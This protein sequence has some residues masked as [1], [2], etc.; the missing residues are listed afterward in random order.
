MV[1]FVVWATFESIWSAFAAAPAPFGGPRNAMSSPTDDGNINVGQGDEFTFVGIPAGP[2]AYAGPLEMRSFTMSNGGT[3]LWMVGVG[4]SG[5]II[6]PTN[7]IAYNTFNAGSA[8]TI[9]SNTIITSFPY[10]D[11]FVPIVPGAADAM[12]DSASTSEDAGTTISVLANDDGTGNAVTAITQGANGGTVTNNGTSVTYNP[13]GQFEYLAVGETAT[14]TFTYTITDG[15]GA[16]DTATVTVTITGAN[17]APQIGAATTINGTESANNNGRNIGGPAFVVTDVDVSDVVTGSVTN[18][19]QSGDKAGVLSDALLLSIAKFVSNDG[20]PLIDATETT[21]PSGVFRFNHG[22]DNDPTRFDFLQAGDVLTLTYTVTATDSQGAS[23]SIIVT[24]NITGENDDP[25]AVD[26]SGMGFTTNEDTTFTTANVLANDTDADMGDVLSVSGFDATSAAGALIT[27]NGDGTFNYNPNGMFDHLAVGETAT[28]TFTYTVS[29]GNG[30]TDTATVTV[31]ITGVNDAP[32]LT[33]LNAYVPDEDLFN[34]SPLGFPNAFQITDVDVNDVVTASITGVTQSGD[35]AGVVSDAEILSHFEIRGGA[36]VIEAG[37]TDSGPIWLTYNA[38]GD[39]LFQFLQAGDVL[40][41][42]LTITVSDG[43]GG[44]DTAVVSTIVSGVNDAPVA[45]DDSGM[46]F[47]TD[48]DTAFTTA[49]VLSNDY[50]PDLGD[51]FSVTAFDGSSMAGALITSNGDGTFNYDPNGMFD[52]LAVGESTTDTFTYTITDN[53]GATDTATVTVTITGVNDAPMFTV[54]QGYMFTNTEDAFN[55]GFALGFPSMPDVLDVD[56]SDVVNLSITGV[57]QSG[58]KAGT[59]SNAQLL[60]YLSPASNPIIGAGVTEGE[61]VVF[62]SSGPGVFDFLQVGDQLELTYSLTATDSQGATDSVVLNLFINGVNDAPVA[63]DD[64]GMG[65]A[66]DEDTAFTTANVLS[67]DYDPDMGDTFSVTAFDASSTAGALITSNGDGTFNYDPNGMFEYLGV[68]ETATDT[69]TYT[70]TDNNGATD[71]TTVTIEIT[72]VNDAPTAQD[73]A[74]TTDEDNAVMGDVLVDNGNGPDTDTDGDP[75]TVNAVNG[76][77]ANVDQQIT[78]ASGALL[79]VNSDGTF[80]YDPNGQFDYLAVGESTTETFTYQVTDGGTVQTAG[81]FEQLILLSSLFAANGGDGSLGF[82]INGPQERS[83]AGVSVSAAGD[84]NGDGIDDF[85]IGAPN[86]SNDNDSA[87]SAFIVFGTDM[88]FDPA[89]ELSSID[90]TNGIELRGINVD[91]RTGFSVSNAGDVNGDGIDD[92]IVGAYVA[93]PNG[94][95]SGK[96]YVVFGTTSP[97]G[98]V[99]DLSTLNGTN[100]F[101]LNGANGFDLSGISVSGGGDVNNDGFS[102][103]I[104]GA[105]FADSNGFAENGKTY[106]VFGGN[107]FG[108]SVELSSLNGANGFA[109]NGAN[110]NFDLSGNAVSNAGDVNADGIDDIVISGI[111]GRY[112]VVFGSDQPFSSTI[113][114]SGLNGT[115]GFTFTGGTSFRNGVSAS[116]AGDINGDGIDDIVVGTG[117]VNS[118]T[119][120]AY[121]IFG[122]AGAFSSTIDASSLNGTNGFIFRGLAQF[123]NLGESVSYAGDINGDGYDDLLIGAYGAGSSFSDGQTYVLFGKA[124]GFS[125]LY[126]RADLD[127]TNGFIIQGGG[128]AGRIG[129]AISAAGDVNGDGIDDLLIG[130]RSG[131]P[132]GILS[133]QSY[134]LFGRATFDAVVDTATVT[135]TVTGVNDAPTANVDVAMADEDN[136]TAPIDV[137]G[138]DTDPDTSDVLTVSSV[139]DSGTTGSVTLNMD[140]TVTYDPNGQFEYLAVGETATDTFEYTVS[141]GN[142]GFDTATVTVTISG[143]NDV[144]TANDDMAVTDE[145]NPSAPINVLS[146]DT[147][148]DTSDVLTV[149]SFDDSATIGSVTL[150]VDGTFTY[151]PNGQFEYLAVGETATDTFE[152]TVSDGN[153]GFDTATVTVTIKGVNDAPE[154]E[155]DYCY[156]PV[157]EIIAGNVLDNDTDVDASDVLTT[158]LVSDVSHG[159]LT[160][161]SDGSFTYVADSG[162]KGVDQ[163]TYLVDDGNGGT[164]TATVTLVTGTF[165]GGVII[166]DDTAETFPGLGEDLYGSDR[167]DGRGGNDLIYALTGDDDVTAGSGDDTVAA[168][169]G[170]DLVKGQGGDDIIVGDAAG[171]DIFKGPDGN[172]TLE[173]NAGNDK[174]AGQGGDDS[175]EGG[176]DDDELQGNDGVDTIRGGKG[177]DLISG[178]A[179]RDR[180]YGNAGNDEICGDEGDDIIRAGFGDDLVFGDNGAD[181]LVGEDGN[182]TMLGGNGRDTM[183][184]GNDDDL[185]FGGAGIDS[186]K[187]DAG[188]DIIVGGDETG[189]GDDITGNDGDDLI[190]G[191]GGEDNLQGSDGQDTILGGIGADDIDGGKDEDILFGEDGNDDI[192]GSAG[193]DKIFGG[194]G[195]DNLNGNDDDDF[196]EGEDGADDI[197]GGHGNDTMLGGNGADSISGSDAFDVEPG[198]FGDD[199]DDKI[200]GENGNDVLEGVN[201]NDFIDGGNHDDTISGGNGDDIL[202]G[203]DGFDVIS[204]DAGDDQIDGGASADTLLGGEGLDTILGADGNDSIEGGVDDDCLD[205]E[206]G[207]DYVAGGAGNDMIDGSAGD[208]VLYGNAGNDV[209]Q[210]GSGNDIVHGNDGDDFIDGGSDNGFQSVEVIDGVLTYTG[211]DNLFGGA[212]NDTLFGNNGDDALYGGDGDDLL[213]G[214]ADGANFNV[215]YGGMHDDTL[216]SGSGTDIMYGEEGADDFVFEILVTTDASGNITDITGNFGVDFIVDFDGNQEDQICFDIVLTDG[217]VGSFSAADFFEALDDFTTLGSIDALIAAGPFAEMPTLMTDNGLSITFSDGSILSILDVSPNTNFELDE[218]LSLNPFADTPKNFQGFWQTDEEVLTYGFDKYDEPFVPGVD[219]TIMD[220]D[221]PVMEVGPFDI[222]SDDF[223]KTELMDIFAEFLH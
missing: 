122:Q 54:P 33:I 77:E 208:D 70:I 119:G 73:D 220:M 68:G 99:L 6:I 201:G 18:V 78:L 117:R 52:Y 87:G 89:F 130:A 181:R 145:D 157:G 205:G 100:G 3:G 35:K 133:G 61:M 222:P 20:G 40:T 221:R 29:D 81:E 75:L 46:G 132:N 194:A 90:G 43:N 82:V 183:R 65:F 198:F 118:G 147:D 26:D 170:D 98:P 93:A 125:A 186:I 88:G 202:R 176:D 139:D 62:F 143:V 102:D 217:S 4:N 182:D 127:G 32:D 48:E 121:V 60:P 23:D 2:S 131:T 148:P 142:G 191:E 41:F 109:V 67:N 86:Y 24:F 137:L 103:L 175:I 160:L 197:R 120:E 207:D 10:A 14:D 152:Y 107:S 38:N 206:G 166:G 16:T 172:D 199:G 200:F 124:G 209:L 150:N 129:D 163:F 7:E 185:L 212:G 135:V 53:N 76:D 210:G 214:G 158:S 92:V 108:A 128:G 47:A 159:T 213:F 42:D 136:P 13:N 97:L 19:V 44:V 30:G 74:F 28:D 161:N 110:A 63:V 25:D 155:D 27:S 17:D 51:T 94:A 12:D 173:G 104:V 49:N 95:L 178:G 64:S 56:V 219:K 196:I 57:V 45:V 113:D 192:D 34:L 151:D 168:G 11:I 165:N 5:G 79:T 188:N 111:A 101:V 123:E 84:F 190:F 144:P 204:G 180:L 141:D 9:T 115:N 80:T 149:D 55:A 162:F 72:G 179:E 69:F 15:N 134:V 36:T 114:V 193:D 37:E 171:K 59:L 96:T 146:N 83:E 195:D 215:Y 187:G 71:T 189:R 167:I 31:N 50:D 211:G 223:T 85:I 138:N 58:D 184:G 140:S 1:N 126:T 106:V 112:Y 177:D 169:K 8:F 66:T 39:P 22:T 153:G 91:D 164:D 105:N 116:N 216:V 203:E 174:I 156:S 21:S 154:A 218:V